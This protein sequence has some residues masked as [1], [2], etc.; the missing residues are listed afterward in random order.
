LQIV[1]TGINSADINM[2][3]DAQLLS[4]LDP[5]GECILHFYDWK[6]PS[7]TYGF[8]IE[9]Q[10]H[11]DLDKA[12]EHSLSWARRPTGG[13]IVF[14]LADFAFSFLMPSRHPRFSL[15][16][17]ENYQFVNEAVLE[18]V[19]DLFQLNNSPA[20]LELLKGNNEQ[21]SQSH[22]CMARPTIYDIVYKN[23]K[24]AGAAQ[25]RSKNGYLHQG[26]ISLGIP[27]A[28]LLEEIIY[29]KETLVS[30]LNYSFAPLGSVWSEAMLTTTREKIKRALSDKL[31][32][33][34]TQKNIYNL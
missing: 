33:K 3:F 17:L 2:A 25:R 8:F 20:L 27:S 4:E 28:H 14:H 6:N 24:I 32:S 15:K 18:L 21:T 23:I 7:I 13:G 22:F 19:E 5:T 30:I 16:T 1:D 12:Q 11:L 10:K 34:L 31:R 29:S 9:L 26:T